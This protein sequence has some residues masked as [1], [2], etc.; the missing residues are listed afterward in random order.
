[1][2]LIEW[3]DCFSE[4]LLELLKDRRMSQYELA[5][6]SGVSSGSISAYINKQS[7]P[8]IKA[9]INIACVLDVD[10][11]ELIDFGDTID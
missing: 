2:T 4:N 6:E 10:V 11:G 1:M 7:L 9:I 3:S 8:G 5:Q